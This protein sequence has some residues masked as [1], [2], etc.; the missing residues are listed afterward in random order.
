MA[1]NFGQTEDTFI[2]KLLDDG[3]FAKSNT[4][5]VLLVPSLE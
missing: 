5:N 4:V 3:N 2:T 1:S